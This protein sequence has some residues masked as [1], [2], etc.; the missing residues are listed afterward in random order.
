MLGPIDYIVVGFR[1]NKFDGSIIGELSKAADAGIIRVVDLVFIMKDADGNVEAGEYTDQP[2]ELK[3][4]FE[5]LGASG[6]EPLFTED[7]IDKVGEQMDKDT[8]AG[9]L[10][11]E[12][13]WAKG[14][15]KAI[16]DAGGMLIADG[17]IHPEMVEAAVKELEMAR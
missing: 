1:G 14:L 3:Q 8:A 7:D 17:R 5:Q 13:L 6:D 9:V 11:I 2:A 15:K 12:H 4:A 16:M 10:V